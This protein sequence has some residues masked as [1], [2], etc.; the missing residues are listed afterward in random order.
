MDNLATIKCTI[1]KICQEIGKFILILSGILMMSIILGCITY[2]LNACNTQLS[3]AIWGFIESIF[4]CVGTLIY[5]VQLYAREKNK[6][7]IYN[8]EIAPFLN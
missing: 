3:C 4:V 8:E 6:K 1:I 5:N 7:P 2:L